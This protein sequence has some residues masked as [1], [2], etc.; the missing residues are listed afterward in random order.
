MK[1][2]VIITFLFYSC[3]FSS[4]SSKKVISK[5]ETCIVLKSTKYD[6]GYGVY[7]VITV[8]DKEGE[9][10]SFRSSVPYKVGTS[11]KLK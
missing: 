4:L 3:T 11:F 6:P 10:I 7:Y 8:K 9:K 1:Y 5:D 2:L